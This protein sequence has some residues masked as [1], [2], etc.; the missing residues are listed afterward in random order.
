MLYNFLKEKELVE[1]KKEFYE[2]IRLREI[3][4]NNKIIDDP[5]F[6]LDNSHN[7]IQIGLKIISR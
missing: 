3:K 2:L 4:V 1:S 6:E 5:N 7:V